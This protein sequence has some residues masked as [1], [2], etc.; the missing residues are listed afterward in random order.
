MKVN[1]LLNIGLSRRFFIDLPKGNPFSIQNNRPSYQ[2]TKHTTYFCCI[3]TCDLHPGYDINGTLATTH[4]VLQLTHR[5]TTKFGLNRVQ[6]QCEGQ[7]WR[8]DKYDL[9]YR[10]GSPQQLGFAH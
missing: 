8:H 9:A 7:A 3:A 4:H 10:L 2:S 5:L 1:I 6:R